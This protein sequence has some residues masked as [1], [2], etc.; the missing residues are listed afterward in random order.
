MLRIH[1]PFHPNQN[2]SQEP[3]EEERAARSGDNDT[4]RHELPG[5]P[6]GSDVGSQGHTW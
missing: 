4:T 2:S 3:V 6:A 5:S 1:T